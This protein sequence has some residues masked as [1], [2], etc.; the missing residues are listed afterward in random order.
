M[1]GV[2][3]L[4]FEVVE[5]KQRQS[6]FLSQID[7]DCLVLIPTNPL[8]IRSNDVH[9]PYRASSYMLYLC[10]WS[11]PGSVFMARHDGEEWKVSL[12]VQPKDTTAEIWEGRRIGVDGAAKGWPIDHANSLLDL[13]EI[14]EQS[15]S[16]S[17]GVYLIQKLN[18]Q[19]D[20][21]VNRS[22]TSKSRQRNT[23]GIGPTSIVDPSS[24][25]DEM[26][27][28][29]SPSEIEIMKKS[30]DLA[31]EAH[32]IAMEKTHSQIAEWEIQAIIEGHFQSKGSQWSYPS[33][34][35]GGDN[36]TILHYHAN[37]KSVK[38]GDLIL[39]DAGCEI[40]GYAS[41]ITR[42]WP[43]NG[44]FSEAQRE[45]YNLV[46]K[47]EIAAI[48]SCQIGSPWNSS[49]RASMEVISRGLIELGILDCS[50]EEAMGDDL[51]G[52]TR[53]FFM[54]GTSHSL[55]LDVHDVGV[56]RPEGKGD[57]RLLEE[58]MVLTVEP[59]LYFGSWREDIT[60]P[61]KYSGIGIRIEDNVVITK[62]GPIVLTS[63]CPKQISEI[64][65]LVGSGV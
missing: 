5:Y 22:L 57:G 46:L 33:I 35:G 28:C 2:T 13:E 9:Y 43:S 64:E 38:N 19:I 11:D 60:I 29:K 32:S 39:V 55:G 63:N 37:N 7:K 40:D 12:F 30:A 61:E 41:D 59:G 53:Q 31:S 49:H 25:L 21:I 10:G 18:Q 24:I 58:G 14:I 4:P 47:A 27:M 1:G 44:K 3:K 54:H 23:H 15:L 26:R 50:F 16:D 56:T 20:E 52:K 42:T 36:A 65:S 45:I 6:R 8:S 51:D 62:E 34:V 17:N 48:E